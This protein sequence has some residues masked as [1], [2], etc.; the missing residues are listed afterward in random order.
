MTLRTKHGTATISQFVDW[1]RSG[2]LNLEP[3]FQRNSVWSTRDRQLLIASI[4]HGIPLPSIYLYKQVGRAGRPV[5]DVIDGKQRLESI[6][7]FMGKGPLAQD[8]GPFTVH[9]S[10]PDDDPSD[11]WSWRELPKAVKARIQATELPTIEVEGDL[12]D[13]INLFVRINATGKK[14]TAQERRHANFHHSATLKTAHRLADEH[15]STFQQHNLLSRAQIQRMKHVELFT[16]LLLSAVN[17][18]Q[19]L[20]KKR[21]IDELI[22]GGSIDEHRL[23]TAAT[24]VKTAIA[25]TL[26]VLPNIKSTRFHRSSDFYS[27]VL[28]LLRLR[29]QGALVNN[30]NSARQRLAG[31]LLTDFGA[32]VDEVQDLIQRGKPVPAA[33]TEHRDYLFTV[34]EGTDSARQRHAREAILRKVVDGVFQEGDLNRVF[35]PTQR[36]ILWNASAKKRCS[37]CLK[38]IERWEELAID[39]VHPYVRGGKTTLA[40]ADILH[41]CCN[42]EKG[43]KTS[44]RGH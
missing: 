9:E 7:L 42:R 23:A 24:A 44:A 11:H 26:T 15:V 31:Q 8:E 20:N 18:G 34:R 2:A 33:K 12:S 14:L 5:Y 41:R 16:E 13:V 27:L 25:N 21:Q 22:A 10:I 3:A 36:R 17:A 43:A 40:N 35:S 32:G 38:P 4:L 39:H 28:L 6:L 30:H 29:D 37:W 1:Y 19:P